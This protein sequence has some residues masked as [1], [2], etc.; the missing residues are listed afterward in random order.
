MKCSEAVVF[1]RVVFHKDIAKRSCE[2]E[3]R[4]WDVGEV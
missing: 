3:R 2:L 4:T 1:V